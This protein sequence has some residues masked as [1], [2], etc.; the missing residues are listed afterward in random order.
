MIILIL[1]DQ[2]VFGWKLF[3]SKAHIQKIDHEFIFH[4]YKFLALSSIWR[5]PTTTVEILFHFVE[6]EKKTNQC[7]FFSFGGQSI[8]RNHDDVLS[9][10][11]TFISYRWMKIQCDLEN[12]KPIFNIHHQHIQIIYYETALKCFT[13]RRKKNLD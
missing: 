1:V 7:F 10:N 2:S 12:D 5:K 13:T 11:K 4:L 3:F 8:F 6:K 9:V